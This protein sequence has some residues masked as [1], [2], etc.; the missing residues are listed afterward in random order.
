MAII[1]IRL[2]EGSLDLL[3]NSEKKFYITKQLH[4]LKDL[5]TRNASF[6]K[7][8][9]IPRTEHNVNLLESNLVETAASSGDNYSYIPCQV[10]MKGSPVVTDARLFIT[11]EDSKSKIININ[12]FGGVVDFFEQVSDKSLKS[13]DVSEYDRDWVLDDLQALAATTEGL[14]IGQAMNVLNVDWSNAVS[15]GMPETEFG[16][17][18]DLNYSG[19]WFYFKTLVTKILANVKGLQ[20]DVSELEEEDIY[21]QMVLFLPTDILFK[22]FSAIDSFSG[23]VYQETTTKSLTASETRLTF[24][25][26]REDE[27]SGFWDSVN[28]EYVITVDGYYDI[29]LALDVRLGGINRRGQRESI[30]ISVYKNNVEL[31]GQELRFV[32]TVRRDYKRTIFMNIGD[33]LSVRV[34][35]TQ[36]DD[37]ILYYTG[38]FGFKGSGNIKNT[39]VK[40]SDYLPDISQKDFIKEVFNFFNVIPTYDNGVI[41][42]VK[43]D[44]ITEQESI[45]LTD[46]VDTMQAQPVKGS[47]STYGQSNVV[48]YTNDED[49]LNQGLN[50]SFP[51]QSD[52][53]NPEKIV[54]Q[55]VF[56]GSDAAYFSLGTMMSVP[57][58]SFEYFDVVG[59]NMTSTF[60]SVDINTTVSPHGLEVGDSIFLLNASGFNQGRR[61][62]IAVQDEFNC[63]LD[64]IANSTTTKPWSFRRYKRNEDLGLRF[65]LADSSFITT[66]I[67]REGGRGYSSVNTKLITFPDELTWQSLTNKY[68]INLIDL[69]KKPVVKSV[70]LRLPNLVFNRINGLKPA[71]ILNQYYYINK[72]EQYNYNKL[73]RAELIEIKNA[74]N[75]SP[76]T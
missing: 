70:W 41:K 22:N 46:Y 60:G 8:L 1:E 20:F 45:D 65:G 18:T 29:D 71:Y 54:L 49:V 35:P 50:T 4:D 61:T 3:P 9:T 17:D 31:V 34:K 23:E 58:F 47:I 69:L 73:C 75:N 39:Y 16:A 53:L 10:F 15:K 66:G 2:E 33:T 24:S 42:F 21:Q 48:K 55:S 30:T 76:I 40:I 11:S 56:S 32:G 7:Q 37:L 72:L 67:M 28:D 51:M 68:Y 5:K 27:P 63:R 74:S 6:S 43:W 19:S 13:L 62:V 59:N 44:E 64:V 25:E 52:E 36:Y 57:M 14:L 38:T 26:T 12:V